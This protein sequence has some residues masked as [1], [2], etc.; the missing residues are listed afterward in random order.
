MISTVMA[1]FQKKMLDWSYHIFLFVILLPNSLCKKEN[2]QEMEAEIRSLLIEFRR[3]KKFHCSSP[4]CLAKR[5]ESTSKTMCTS[6]KRYPRKCSLVFCLCFKPIC[7][8]VSTSTDIKTIM[9]STSEMMMVLVRLNQVL[10]N[11]LPAQSLWANYRRSRP[12]SI[13][14]E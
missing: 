14:K 4:M 7:L 11:L 8:A 12:W 5:R 3:K 2:S 13:P 9:K 10:L 1:T 6:I